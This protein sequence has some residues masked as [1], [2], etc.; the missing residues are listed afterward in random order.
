MLMSKDMHDVY[1]SCLP[2]QILHGMEETDIRGAKEASGYD[3]RLSGCREMSRED[4]VWHLYEASTPIEFV[5]L[6]FLRG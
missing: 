3:T 6:V 5:Y 4:T 2:F 1:L